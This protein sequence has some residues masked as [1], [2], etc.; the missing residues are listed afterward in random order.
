MHAILLWLAIIVSLLLT[1]SAIIMTVIFLLE[2]S[3][4]NSNPEIINWIEN[5][6]NL[7]SNLIGA[8]NNQN[9]NYINTHFC[10]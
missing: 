10:V 6:L 2:V 8:I 7:S 3:V 4:S 1:I 5:K 9:I